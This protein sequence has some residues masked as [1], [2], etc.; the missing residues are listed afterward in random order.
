MTPAPLGLHCDDCGYP[1]RGL[2]RKHVCPECGAAYDLTVCEIRLSR[3][4]HLWWQLGGA[5]LLLLSVIVGL[6]RGFEI[7]GAAFFLGAYIVVLLW[8]LR[9]D[10]A[11]D[12]RIVLTPETATIIIGRRRQKIALR[13]IRT[14][15]FNW[16]RHRLELIDHTGRAIAQVSAT[17]LGGIDRTRSVAKR[18]VDWVHHAAPGDRRA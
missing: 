2:P 6:W 18:I 3:A 9:R 11:A 16:V 17:H 4:E 12:D 5:V 8:K 14:A 10:Q 1:L 13:D 7:W 15:R